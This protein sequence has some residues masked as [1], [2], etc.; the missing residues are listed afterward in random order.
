VISIDIS[1]AFDSVDRSKLMEMLKDILEED[2]WRMILYILTPTTIQIKV[3]QTL[4]KPF[5][6]NV[7]LPQ[8]D[9]LSPLLFIF[10]LTKILSNW[11]HLESFH[12][13]LFADDVDL[14]NTGTRNEL[15]EKEATDSLSKCLNDFNL[16]L[17]ESKTF[18]YQLGQRH[19]LKEIKKL[20]AFMLP[21]DQITY[22]S[23]KASQAFKKMWPIW[24][25]KNK[26]SQKSKLKIYN[27]FILPILTHEISSHSISKTNLSPLEK[28]YRKHLRTVTKLSYP[29]M[30]PNSR[31]Y[32]IAN[33]PTLWYRIT[34]GR[35]KLLRSCLNLPTDH[36]I[37][38]TMT[39]Y[40][41][42][43]GDRR[44][45][46]GLLPEII[47]A[48]MRKTKICVTKVEDLDKLRGMATS[49]KEWKEITKNVLKVTRKE[50]STSMWHIYNEGHFKRRETKEKA[51]LEKRQVIDRCEFPCCRNQATS[52]SPSLRLSVCETHKVST[53][54]NLHI[55]RISLSFGQK[56]NWTK[57]LR[58]NKDN[59]GIY[60]YT[61][62][63]KT[64]KKK[65]TNQ[66]RRK[67]KIEM[68][69][70]K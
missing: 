51:I 33:V 27:S 23:H 12:F 24:Y 32:K 9:A 14:I 6:G 44:K 29:L 53:E 50:N 47:V 69:K 37:N 42:K 55:A 21:Q 26:L 61:N 60:S 8:G 56:A 46:R 38:Q 20:G 30:V 39:N 63:K 66:S 65:C 1:K 16:T 25:R 13:F 19:S 36:P 35:L 48:M 2:E 43:E 59:R 34:K 17:N 10:Y 52:I 41:L 67:T 45:S 22:N 3:G 31:L 68:K 5:T 15:K 54:N 18:S 70:R 4:S 49:N 57:R 7:G 64:K 62:R 40:F 58:R 11:E 28:I